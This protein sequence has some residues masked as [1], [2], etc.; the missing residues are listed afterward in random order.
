MATSALVRAVTR[1]DVEALLFEKMLSVDVVEMEEVM[2]SVVPDAVVVLTWTCGANVVVAPA[3]S[4]AVV[5]E[6][7]PVPP[8]TGVMQVQPAGGVMAW[9]VVFGG[10]VKLYVGVVAVFAPRFEMTCV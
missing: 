1:F 8:T 6:I 7:V 9:N 2:L 5:Q 4:E 3:A 10:V